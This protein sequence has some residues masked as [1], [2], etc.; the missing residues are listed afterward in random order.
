M[1]VTAP[2]DPLG[3][4]SGTTSGTQR[5]RVDRADLDSSQ[6]L[7]IEPSMPRHPSDRQFLSFMIPGATQ[8]MLSL[9]QLIETLKHTSNDIVGIPG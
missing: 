1:P 5:T 9:V 6:T 3:I 7:N 8:V 2:T 4:T